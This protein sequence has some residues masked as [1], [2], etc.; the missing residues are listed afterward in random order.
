[1]SEESGRDRIQRPTNGKKSKRRYSKSG[2]QR[3]EDSHDTLVD[4]R[5][6]R[7]RKQILEEILVDEL[8]EE[9]YP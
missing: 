5:R 3:T 8:S 9:Q 4:R 1:M 2:K 6:R 7:A